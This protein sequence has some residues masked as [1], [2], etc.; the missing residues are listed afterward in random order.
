MWLLPLWP[1]A[2]IRE[3][4]Y[5]AMSCGSLACYIVSTHTWLVEQGTPLLAGWAQ[6][7]CPEHDVLLATSLCTLPL[8][9]KESA[10]THTVV[11]ALLS[12]EAMVLTC[13]FHVF[14]HYYI[15]PEKLRDKY[16]H[17]FDRVK[18]LTK[19]IESCRRTAITVSLKRNGTIEFIIVGGTIGVNRTLDDVKYE[20]EKVFP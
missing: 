8:S 20:F 11:Q 14:Q 5:V 10:H 16:V 4:Y 6:D 19:A 18:S 2:L 1:H 7:Q 15:A 12:G 13:L 9:S 17:Y 3:F